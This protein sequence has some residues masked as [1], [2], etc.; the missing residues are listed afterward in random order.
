M[1]RAGIPFVDGNPLCNFGESLRNR[2]VPKVLSQFGIVA[3]SL[4]RP[5]ADGRRK[6]ASTSNRD[7]AVP[8]ARVR[9]VGLEKGLSAQLAGLV[10]FAVL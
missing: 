6:A 9:R 5:S 3:A 2:L 10:P 1:P 7:G 4:P 8:R